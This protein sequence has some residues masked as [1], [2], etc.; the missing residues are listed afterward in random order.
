MLNSGTKDL[1]KIL[2]VRRVGKS[3][4]VSRLQWGWNTTVK[5]SLFRL[6]LERLRM[7][8]EVRYQPRSSIV[9]LKPVTTIMQATSVVNTCTY[10]EILTNF[11]K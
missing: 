10:Q 4:F 9:K 3:N 8:Q 5:Q 7:I 2:S 1:E 11:K 6:R